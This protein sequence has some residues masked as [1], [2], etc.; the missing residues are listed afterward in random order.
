MSSA[1]DVLIIGTGGTFD[2]SYD[3]VRERLAFGEPSSLPRILKE[4]HLRGCSFN[5]VMRLDSLDM[6]DSHRKTLAKCI[7]DDKRSRFVVVHGTSRLVETGIFLSDKIVDRTVVLTGAL[8]PFLYSETE[9]SANLGGAIGVSRILN[10]GVYLFMHGRVFSP[11]NCQKNAR[12]GVF[13]E[14]NC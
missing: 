9:A 4:A 5:D 13:E 12:T 10:H 2:K 3:A 11:N 7:L 1:N 6:T 8:C 14:L